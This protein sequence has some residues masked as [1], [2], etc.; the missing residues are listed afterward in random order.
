TP[1]EIRDQILALLFAAHETSAAALFWSVYLLAEHPCALHR[2]EQELDTVLA[3]SAPCLADLAELPYTLQVVRESMR[4]FP[5]AGR[6]FRV[7]RQ[8]TT[9]DEYSIPAGMPIAL[10]QYALHRR[11]ES[12]PEPDRFDPDR[13]ATGNI[14][15]HP[16][17]YLPFGAGPLT[18]A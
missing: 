2:I 4:L 14:G 6:Q 5:A 10:C 1:E 8:D 11:A 12:F 16:L 3:G 17:A 13:F 9:L 18:S 15:R 7:A